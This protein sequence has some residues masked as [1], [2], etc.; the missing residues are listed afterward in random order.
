[1]TYTWGRTWRWHC[2]TLQHTATHCDDIHC[3][4]KNVA[5]A[6]HVL[7]LLFRG[8]S[9]SSG[10]C[11]IESETHICVSKKLRELIFKT[12]DDG[13]ATDCGGA[14][15]LCDMTHAYV[16]T[17][18]TLMLWNELRTNHG[19]GGATNCWG[20]TVRAQL[21]YVTWVNCVMWHDSTVFCD[22]SDACV[23]R[24]V[25]CKLMTEISRRWECN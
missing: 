24:Q 22:M 19:D 3:M 11:Q 17:Q 25:I 16:Y 15:G 9:I 8:C 14:S 6:D 5:M 7:P 23:L 1:M 18:M 20:V 12:R 21:W 4:R 10:I 13:S 2:N